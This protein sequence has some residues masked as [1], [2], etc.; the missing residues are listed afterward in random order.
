MADIALLIATVDGNAFTSANT[1]TAVSVLQTALTP[2]FLLVALGQMLNLFSGRLTRIVDRT[3]ALEAVYPTS[4]GADH[5][6]VVAELRVCEKRLAIV[7]RAILLGVLAAIVVAIM[8]AL[9]FFTGLL[10][11]RSGLVIIIAFLL[12]L[13]LLTGSLLYFVREVHLATSIIHVREEYL[14][15]DTVER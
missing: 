1:A 2:A 4:T 12:A 10:G 11:A 9:L 3:R 6:R 13:A 14:E 5:D 7:G 8:I 15:H